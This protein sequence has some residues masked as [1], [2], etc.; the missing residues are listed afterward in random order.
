MLGIICKMTLNYLLEQTEKLKSKIKN[1]DLNEEDVRHGFYG[2]MYSITYDYYIGRVTFELSRQ[3]GSGKV[4]FSKDI[5][6]LEQHINRLQEIYKIDLLRHDFNSTLNRNLI[7][8]SWTSFET[9]VSLI[10]NHYTTETDIEGIIKDLN[11]KLVK[12]ITNLEDEF[13]TTIIDILKTSSFIPLSRKINFLIKN[14]DE[15][16][17]STLKDDRKFIEFFS[18]MRNS[19]VHSNGIYF[20]KKRDYFFYDTHFV[21]ENGKVLF[22]QGI[23]QNV[24]WDMSF[25]LIEIFDNLVKGMSNI[26]FIEYP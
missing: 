5:Y 7:L 10:F 23:N 6:D 8:G 22:Q 21:F 4:F 12:A 3:I 15:E 16:Y 11:S 9:C 14:G 25:R 18:T 24:T 13:Q 20:G 19:L 1:L 26:E 17:G 2:L